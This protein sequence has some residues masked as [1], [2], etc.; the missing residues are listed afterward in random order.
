MKKYNV[1]YYLHIGRNRYKR[2]ALVQTTS[3]DRA[4]Q[5][6]VDR[7]TA[8]GYQFTIL[9]VEESKAFGIL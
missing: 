5:I 3:E 7:L 4:K 8:K 1:W 2:Y 9:K 6:A